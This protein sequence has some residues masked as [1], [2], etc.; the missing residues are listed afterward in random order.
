MYNLTQ[1][2]MNKIYL[3][4][5]C[6]FA[7]TTYQNY[8]VSNKNFNL[9]EII[10]SI[11]QNVSLNEKGI[12]LKHNFVELKLLFPLFEYDELILINPLCFNLHGNSQWYSFL[13]SLL[14]VLNDNYL[15][16]TN[17]VKKLIL[18]TANKTYQKKIIIDNVFNDEIIKNICSIT[19]IILISINF[20][21]IKI[22]NYNKD[23][24]TDLKVVVLL[25]Y[26][27]QYFPVINWSKKY[28]NL[29]SQF[30]KYLID[31]SL[32]NNDNFD[33]E[34]NKSSDYITVSKKK[35]KKNDSVNNC[36]NEILN[37]FNFGNDDKVHKNNIKISSGKNTQINKTNNL[38]EQ[39]ELDELD[40]FNNQNNQ[41]NQNLQIKLSNDEDN[42]KKNNENQ[43]KDC[44]KE[45]T[46]NENY[47]IYISEAVDND[48]ILKKQVSIDNKK[49]TK[50][51]KNIFVT[52]HND[53]IPE[54]EVDNNVELVEKNSCDDNIINDTS[55]FAKTEKITKKDIDVILGNLKPT[56]NLE[57][58]QAYGIKLGISIFEGSTKSG[59]PKNKTK[60]EL[61]EKI[62]EFCK[63]YQ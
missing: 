12:F 27:E 34:K 49:K 9:D 59:K 8:E 38:F 40:E 14:S 46:T 58:I 19:N 52:T 4:K 61:I 56:L 32:L 53:N 6:E 37:N 16:E 33:V 1:I 29:N 42:T 7:L 47:A 20:S 36:N 31:K 26:H 51:N 22:Y 24:N 43:K 28:Y 50:K 39:F 3:D 44:Y 35:N 21:K 10:N 18:E 13:N 48:D 30:V 2:K 25:N 15:H 41:N 5:L 57:Q 23:N 11:K 54:K 60:S 62:K 17:L 55:T 63:S 45:L